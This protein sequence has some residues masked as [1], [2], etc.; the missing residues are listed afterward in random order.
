MRQCLVDSPP[1]HHVTTPENSQQYLFHSI[2]LVVFLAFQVTNR[3][4]GSGQNMVDLLSGIL[5][6][7]AHGSRRLNKGAPHISKG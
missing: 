4:L 1:G 3:A 7:G 5:G 2:L 6:R